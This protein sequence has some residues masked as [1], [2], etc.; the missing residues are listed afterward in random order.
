[1]WIQHL[2]KEN[3]ASLWLVAYVSTASA[4][5]ILTSGAY[6]ISA[7]AP[8]SAIGLYFF[9]SK[10]NTNKIFGSKLF[11]YCIT[12]TL[13]VLFIR[14]YEFYE[15][16]PAPSTVEQSQVKNGA[17]KYLYGANEKVEQI[18]FIENSLKNL[19]ADKTVLFVNSYAGG[20]LLTAARDS[21]PATLMD[22]RY[23]KPLAADKIYDRYFADIK[24]HP[25]Y[26]VE[27]KYYIGK[28]RSRVDFPL[29]DRNN[30]RR[31]LLEKGSYTLIQDDPQ[32]ALYKITD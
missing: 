26:L 27:V 17:F 24:M 23:I 25:H 8:M 9:L 11:G 16:Y 12:I 10:L 14:T 6:G 29:N 21:G 22:W 30:L 13:I 31:I 20:Y 28:D 19:T 18:A 3:S 15:Y 1:M 5:L 7:A 4:I 2:R 32:L